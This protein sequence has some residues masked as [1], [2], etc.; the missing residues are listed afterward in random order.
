MITTTRT[1]I[2]GN[3]FTLDIVPW[4]RTI[5]SHKENWRR[6]YIVFLFSSSSYWMMTPN[7]VPR[8]LRWWWWWWWRVYCL[9]F[10]FFLYIH[11]ILDFVVF[12]YFFRIHYWWHASLFVICMQWYGCLCVLINN[13]SHVSIYVS[14]LQT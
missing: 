13:S 3:N 4:F 12:V 14:N 9:R 7:N 6:P 8:A 5:Y 11:S 10:F 1:T 2:T